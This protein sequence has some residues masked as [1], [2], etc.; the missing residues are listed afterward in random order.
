MWAAAPWPHKTMHSGQRVPPAAQVQ[1]LPVPARAAAASGHALVQHVP[2]GLRRL[3]VQSRLQ[4]LD[5]LAML[6]T[7][8]S[9]GG[10]H[11]AAVS[12]YLQHDRR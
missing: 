11:R 3:Q 9:A 2:Q 8:L 4:S 5:C 7:Q 10:Q 12:D 1:R 6:K